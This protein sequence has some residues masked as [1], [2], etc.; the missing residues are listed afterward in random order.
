MRIVKVRQELGNHICCL[1][2]RNYIFSCSGSVSSSTV[3][4]SVRLG[5]AHLC[6]QVSH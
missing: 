5:S 4:D 3:G 2:K 1:T 6:Y